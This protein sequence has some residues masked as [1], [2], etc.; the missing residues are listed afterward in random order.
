MTATYACLAPLVYSLSGNAGLIASAIAAGV[1][2]FG[3]VVGLAM[4]SLFRTPQ[5]AMHGVAVSMLART[6]LPLALGLTLQMNV[7]SLADAGFVY[8]LLV[9][10][11]VTLATETILSVAQLTGGSNHSQAV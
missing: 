10:Y 5:T 9:F 2:C 11:G 6:V 7:A 1:C 8:Y 4:A 3:G